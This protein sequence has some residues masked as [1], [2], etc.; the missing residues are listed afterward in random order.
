MQKVYLNNPH[1][2]DMLATPVAYKL[3]RIKPHLKYQYFF[4]AFL[5]RGGT[6]VFDL[7]E[8]SFGKL[9]GFKRIFSPLILVEIIMWCLINKVPARQIRF[10]VPKGGKLVIFT[11]KGATHDGLIKRVNLANASRI[12]WHLSHYMVHTEKKLSFVRKY[13][14]KSTLMADSNIETNKLFLAYAGSLRACDFLLLPFVPN[15]RFRYYKSP[16]HREFSKI[17]AT[18]TWHKLTKKLDG[19]DASIDIFKKT[20]HHFLRK[21]IADKCPPWVDDGQGDFRLQKGL[22]NRNY[23]D[24][25]LVAT[26]NQYA[27]IVCGDELSGAPAISNFEAMCCGALPIVYESNYRGLG[28]QKGVHYLA[29]DGSMKGLQRAFNLVTENFSIGLSR[30]VHV[31]DLLMSK[32]EAFLSEIFGE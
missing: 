29:H 2:F 6:C 18:G 31:R 22:R 28:L 27:S 23:F 4:Q 7:S 5:E 20:S 15:E 32:N 16:V 24:R 10:L 11:Y 13:V 8:T 14:R 9:K 19:A 12:Y 1:S 30:R 21:E 17:F 3:S 25:D 26:F